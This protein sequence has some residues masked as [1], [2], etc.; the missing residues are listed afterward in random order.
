MARGKAPK[1][2]HARKSK[3][4]GQ[5]RVPMNAKRAPFCCSFRMERTPHLALKLLLSPASRSRR[6]ARE[7]WLRI[8]IEL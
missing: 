6:S 7:E 5:R 1:R 2:P 8:D 4:I 3:R